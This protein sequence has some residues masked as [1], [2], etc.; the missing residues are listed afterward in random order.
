MT[1]SADPG[2]QNS[3]QFTAHAQAVHAGQVLAPMQVA[4]I[5]VQ[6]YPRAQDMLAFVNFLAGDLDEP[7]QTDLLSA[8]PQ[9]PALQA[10]PQAVPQQQ[11]QP[12]SLPQHQ[13]QPHGEEQGEVP[14]AASPP[15][16]PSG[17]QQQ[18]LADPRPSSEFWATM[19]R[20]M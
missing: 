12:Q 13:Q 16:D 14:A 15:Q 1:S 5:I 2:M 8:R 7:S 10:Q 6:S 4:T 11:Q 19:K 20:T 3:A 9:Q 18:F 17:Q